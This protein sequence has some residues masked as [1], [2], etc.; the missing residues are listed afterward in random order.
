MTEEWKS[1]LNCGQLQDQ[2]FPDLFASSTLP[3]TNPWPWL[4]ASSGTCI[5]RRLLS[6]LR[7]VRIPWGQKASTLET[8]G[9]DPHGSLS[10]AAGRANTDAV[11]EGG[12]YFINISGFQFMNDTRFTVVLPTLDGV[13]LNKVENIASHKIIKCYYCLKRIRPNRL[14]HFTEYF[15]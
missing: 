13:S 10:M 11:P 3:H 9:P 6:L 4:W 8:I 7:N 1:H 5:Y 12:G 15:S 2:Q 14:G